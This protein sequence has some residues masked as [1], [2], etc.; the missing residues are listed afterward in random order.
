MCLSV[1]IERPN[2]VLANGTHEGHEWVVTHSNGFRC[3]YVKVEP[4]HPWHGK[5]YQD[6]QSVKVHGGLTFGQPDEPCDKGGT[7]DGWW[8]GF[9]CG[10]L[11]DEPDP[12]LPQ[13][14]NIRYANAFPGMPGLV[15]D[16][17]AGMME[18]ADDVC[19]KP[20]DVPEGVRSQEY[21]EAECRK[22]CEQAAAAQRQRPVK[23]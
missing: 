23:V 8:L 15:N 4:G 2:D 13:D 12:K 17:M 7:D 6:L 3:G 10:H 5:P 14:G 9:D 20:R 11:G 1:A 18:I 19:S 21:V 16:F 22:L